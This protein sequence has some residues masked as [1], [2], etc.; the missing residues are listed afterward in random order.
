MRG[1]DSLIPRQPDACIVA[2]PTSLDVVVAHKGVVR[3]RCHTLGR[4]AHSS[5]PEHGENAIFA[6]ADVLRALQT[7]Q[8][9]VA[10]RL[11]E[12]PLCGHPT[13][14]VGV[15]S[16]GLSVNTVPDRCTIEID[17]RLLPAENPQTARQHVIDFVAQHVVASR[18]QH[19][20]PMM[21]SGGMSDATPASL[22]ARLD[23]ISPQ[24][25]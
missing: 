16:G 7:Y 23:A 15:I 8:A 13:L 19:D 2:E 10:P 9:D 12:H 24:V 25:S 11:G 17:R 21:S 3:W 18:V 1:N 22:A 5:R 20:A 4:A 6:M 14:S